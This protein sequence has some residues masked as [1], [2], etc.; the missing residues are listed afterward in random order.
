[1]TFGGWINMGLSV[2]FVTLLFLWCV[3]KVLFRRP[4]PP[5]EHHLAHVEPIESDQADER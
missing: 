5:P 2:G 3:S 4:P 1:M